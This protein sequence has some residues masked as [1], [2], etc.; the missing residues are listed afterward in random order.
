MKK[1]FFLALAFFRVFLFSEE[2]DSAIETESV[3]ANIPP[4][5]ELPI[6][7][8]LNEPPASPAATILPVAQGDIQFNEKRDPEADDMEALRRWIRDKRFVTVK[9]LGGDLSISGEARTEFQDSTEVKNGVRQRGEGAATNRPQYAWDSEV[10]I[11]IDYRTDRAWAVIK[12][13]F[14]NDMGIRSGTVNRLR[15]EKGYFGGRLVS[16]DTFTFDVEI[17]RRYLF[18]VFDSQLEFSSLF[19]G[20]LFRFNKAW[21]SIGNFYCNLGGLLVDDKKNHY[22]YVTEIGGL[23]IANVGLNIKYSIINWY[24]PYANELNDLRFK[25]LNSQLLISY[26]YSPKWLGKR[27]LKFY[28]AGL[29]NH[30]ASGVPQTHNKRQ[31]WAWYAGFSIGVDKKQY[32]F[33][34]NAN[35]QWA[36]AQA[37]SDFDGNGIGRGNTEGVGL[38]TSNINGNPNS[39]ATTATTT[40][41]NGNYHGFEL[42]GLYAF[43]DNLTLLQNFRYADTLNHSIGPKMKYRQYEME[44]IYAF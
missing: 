16:G 33:A 10:N 42:Q 5:A 25:F 4:A 37:L 43:T 27:M 38:Y 11:M 32:D 36:Q 29:I 3:D 30:L 9:E 13:E 18:N 20:I 2:V 24:K 26:L 28:A 15:L 7:S 17:G 8:E 6:S 14:D 19:D 31:N 22:A 12:V 44:F 21:L 41:G 1:T 40:V 35:Y 34:I 39:G 23:R